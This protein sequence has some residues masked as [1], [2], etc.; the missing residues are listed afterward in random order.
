[1]AQRIRS[2][3][4]IKKNLD[5]SNGLVKENSILKDRVH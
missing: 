3:S 4:L 2:Y 1:M 5:N